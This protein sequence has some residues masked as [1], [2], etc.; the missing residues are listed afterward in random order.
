MG[1]PFVTVARFLVSPKQMID[2]H[3][4]PF[5]GVF[6]ILYIWCRLW[7]IDYCKIQTCLNIGV[8]LCQGD[9]TSVNYLFAQNAGR[10]WLAGFRPA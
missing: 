1:R 10:H 2:R 5:C 6:A 9:E 7:K 3:R 4:L 8:A